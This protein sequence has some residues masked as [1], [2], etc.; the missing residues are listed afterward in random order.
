M[1][2]ILLNVDYIRARMVDRGMFV[3]FHA[4]DIGHGFAVEYWRGDENN[5]SCLRTLHDGRAVSITHYRTPGAA[6]R[7]LHAGGYPIP[8]M[9]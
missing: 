1:T 3:L 9:A 5:G 8:G 2:P 4:W 6:I 7:I